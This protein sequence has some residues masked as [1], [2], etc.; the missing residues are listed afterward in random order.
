MNRYR[1]GG[2]SKAAPTT[3]CQKCLKR[4]VLQLPMIR[5]KPAVQSETTHRTRNEDGDQSL[6]HQTRTP[7][8]PFPLTA[9]LRALLH[10]VE[11]EEKTRL[12][13]GAEMALVAKA[14]KAADGKGP[15][16]VRNMGLAGIH[17]QGDIESEM[18][19][20]RDRGAV[21]W[22]PGLGLGRRTEQRPIQHEVL[23]LPSTGG[24]LEATLPESDRR[25]ENGV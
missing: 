13:S 24:M 23:E 25:C 14:R 9:P 7:Y 15:M 19:L 5:S 20:R 8:R 4:G 12:G 11:G 16:V 1:A 17:L 3:L 2:P 18:R 10:R 22:F 21:E 6:T